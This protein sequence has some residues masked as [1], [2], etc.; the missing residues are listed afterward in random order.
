MA[1]LSADQL[2]EV[3]LALMIENAQV[4]AAVGGHDPVLS[5]DSLGAEYDAALDEIN[6]ARAG[7]KASPFETDLVFKL[8]VI[9]TL[10]RR[11]EAQGRVHGR[12]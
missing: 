1:R 11:M 10:M 6:Q 5:V 7:V 8:E 4:R 12:Q 2:R 3:I 9:D